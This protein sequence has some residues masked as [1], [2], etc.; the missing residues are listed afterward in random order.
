MIYLQASPL[1]FRG[2]K[3]EDTMFHIWWTCPHIRSYWNKVFHTLSKI[4]ALTISPD[5]TIALL[6]CKIPMI[7][8]HMQ[9]ITFYHLPGAKITLARAWKKP[10]LFRAAKRKISWIMS[11]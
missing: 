1:C 8:K 10:T 4:I 2:C 6:N 9:A 11:Q 5:P 7:Y 3:L